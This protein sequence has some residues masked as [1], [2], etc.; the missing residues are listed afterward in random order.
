MLTVG[1]GFFRTNYEEVPPDFPAVSELSTSDSLEFDW[2]FHT[3]SGQEKNFSNYKGKIIFLNF[4][5]TWCGPCKAEMPKI[6]NLYDQMKD[7]EVVFLLMSNEK[8]TTL[9]H[10]LSFQDYELPVCNVSQKTFNQ[11][12]VTAIPTTL[13]IDR[14]GFVVFKHTGAAKWDDA[15]CIKFLRALLEKV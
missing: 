3:L 7:R 5:A 11:F 13:I 8:L 14:N 6:Q 1:C 4:W 2:T 12:D 9:K 10:F 15:S